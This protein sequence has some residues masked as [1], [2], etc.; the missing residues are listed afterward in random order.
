MFN[1]LTTLTDND[2]IYNVQNLRLEHIK[3]GSEGYADPFK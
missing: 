3:K 1:S 2:I